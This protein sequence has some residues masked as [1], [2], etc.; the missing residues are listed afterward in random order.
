[1]AFGIEIDK[2]VVRRILAHRYRPQSGGSFVADF[3]RHS[4]QP[5]EL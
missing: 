2:D 5:V 1:M 3:S 4:R